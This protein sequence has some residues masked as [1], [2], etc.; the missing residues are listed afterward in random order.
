MVSTDFP[1]KK[2]LNNIAYGL[3]YGFWFLMSLLP[4]RILYLISDFLY[5]IVARVMKYRYEIIWKNLRES[6]PEKSDMEIR[7]IQ[8]EFYRWFCDYVVETVKL[9]TM[10]RKTLQKR[11]KFTGMEQCIKVFQEGGSC[12]VYL[13]HYCNWE[14]ISTLPIWLSTEV[15]CC[16]LYHPLEN[17]CFDPLFKVVR[18]RQKAVCIPMQESLRKILGFKRDGNPMAVG[19]IADQA[20]LWWNIHHWVD[21]LHHDTPVLTGTER[22]VKHADQ[23]C[24]YGWLTRP[25]RGYYVCEMKLIT[26]TPSEENE[27]AITDAYFRLL[28]ENIKHA[29]A[30]YL[31]SHNRWKRTRE[32]FERDWEVVD[33]KVLRKR[34]D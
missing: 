26:L 18:E 10:S 3:A 16:Q 29:P 34:N 13:G 15:K 8:R 28:E 2:M 7:K 31:W 4:F 27:F 33:G 20:P 5:L 9:M 32:E 24:F 22:I 23:A 14:W 12:A 30:F 1:M 17:K 6:F 19:Y 21:F 11:M 25:K